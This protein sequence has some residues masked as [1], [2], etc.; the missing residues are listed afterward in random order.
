MMRAYYAQLVR[1][2]GRG[3]APRAVH[4]QMLRGDGVSECG[5]APARGVGAHEASLR[6]PVYRGGVIEIGRWT[7]MAAERGGQ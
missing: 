1:G 3:V 2:D 4:L 7:P 5:S 6:H